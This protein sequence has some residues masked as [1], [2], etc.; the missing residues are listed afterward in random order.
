MQN[1]ACSEEASWTRLDVRPEGRVLFAGTVIVALIS[2]AM[3]PTSLAIASTVLGAFMV[4]GTDTDIRTYLLPD[5]I[6]LGAL[7]CGV[8]A[9]FAL[10]SVEAAGLALASALITA[11][12]LAM[13]R[14]GY[15]WKRGR[16]GIGLGDV[17]LAGAIG[18]WLPIDAIPLCFLLATASALIAIVVARW[19]GHSFARNTRIPFGAFLCPSLWL[20]FFLCAVL[21][22]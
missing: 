15:A 17:K 8:L 3:L 13:V 16:E 18:A 2:A 9:Q 5:M 19:R 7:V 22:R 4:A 12:I 20:V 6:T 10:A 21:D 11:L 1:G 14:W